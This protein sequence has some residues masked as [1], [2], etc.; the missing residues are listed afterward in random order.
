MRV[1]IAH[2]LIVLFAWLGAGCAFIKQ[3]TLPSG[4][5][6]SIPPGHTAVF[7]RVEY[8]TNSRF[9]DPRGD[10]SMGR[11]D[12]LALTQSTVRPN[13][14]GG[15]AQ[16]AD[17]LTIHVTIGNDFFALIRRE[18]YYRL[19]DYYVG[20]TIHCPDLRIALRQDA[21][22][23]YVGKLVFQAH[24]GE[25]YLESIALSVVDE[26]EHAVARL[27]QR[28]P[29]LRGQI[30]KSLFSRESVPDVGK[31]DCAW[32]PPPTGGSVIPLI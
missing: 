21:A 4:P 22:A 31:V 10:G 1:S 27:K 3:D 24:Y 17:P 6:V 11:L 7:G 30:A 5:N 13:K 19:G 29:G 12:F 2:L 23:V 8:K 16:S 26:Y 18:D 9:F 25:F 20:I 32:T 28:N 14:E 15:A